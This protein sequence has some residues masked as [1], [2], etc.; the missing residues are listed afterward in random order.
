M[1]VR[2]GKKIAE[3]VPCIN[4]FG[5]FKASTLHIHAKHCT[6]IKSGV[7]E[8]RA[9][10]ESSLSSTCK[11]GTFM[12]KIVSRLAEGELKAL[13]KED[14]GIKLYGTAMFNKLGNKLGFLLYTFFIEH[15]H[16]HLTYNR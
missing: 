16:K 2:E 6:G 15:K 10:L 9:F 1:V 14:D 5:F 8:S 11:Y 3:T 13:I 4:C 12:E 7:K